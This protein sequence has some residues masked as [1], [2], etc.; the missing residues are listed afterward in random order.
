M[1]PLPK[2][3]LPECFFARRIV[4]AFPVLLLLTAFPCLAH[5]YRPLATEDA[6]VLDPLNFEFEAGTD[7][8]EAGHGDRAVG[9]LYSLNAGIVK[10]FEADL[11]VPVYYYNKIDG[12]RDNGFGDLGLVGKL[13]LLDETNRRPAVLFAGTLFFPTSQDD[14]NFGST[15]TS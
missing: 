6:S 3:D 7:Y 8:I 2:K 11:N 13:L 9:S 4:S 14:K 1:I 12:E 15:E 5:A 10:R